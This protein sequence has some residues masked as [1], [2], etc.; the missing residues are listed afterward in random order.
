MNSSPQPL[1]VTVVI[2]TYNRCDECMR[3]VASA[4]Q[5]MPPPLEVLVCDDGS[6]DATQAELLRWQERESRLRYLRI[7]PNRGTPAPARNLG[8]YSARGEWV[9][10]LDDDD[11]W[12]TGKLALQQ[13]LLDT[14]VDVIASDAIRSDGHRYFGVDGGVSHPTRAELERANPVILSTALVRRSLLL[15]VGGFDENPTIAGVEDYDLWLRLADRGARFAILNVA[16]VQYCDRGDARLSSAPLRTQRMIVGV[17]I[18]RWLKKPLDG[19][20]LRSAAHDCATAL[21]AHTAAL[22]PSRRAGPE[23]PSHRD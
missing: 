6:T 17:R 4:L 23:Q 8:A 11:R 1:S 10:F 3:A 13:S 2:T 20:R 15:D 7:E 18:R 16:T 19:L 5:Q 14:G 9:G 22:R 21:L 12:L